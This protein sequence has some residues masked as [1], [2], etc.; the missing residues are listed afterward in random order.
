MPSTW[1]DDPS[2][3]HQRRAAKPT[4]A[5]IQPATR[6]HCLKDGDAFRPEKQATVTRRLPPA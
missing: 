3:V 4:G 5:K 6:Y 1:K 2:R